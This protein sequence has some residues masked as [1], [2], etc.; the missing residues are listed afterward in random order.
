MG[1]AQSAA[2]KK[3]ASRNVF[4]Q[5]RLSFFSFEVGFALTF[6]LNFGA[7]SCEGYP[8][9]LPRDAKVRLSGGRCAPIRSFNDLY[10]FGDPFWEAFSNML[11][12]LRHPVSE[13]FFGGVQRRTCK[14]FGFVL[15][16][17]SEAFSV[18]FQE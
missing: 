15:G 13:C 12:C 17:F 16:A 2:L 7:F 3:L 4:G 9:S 11:L 5:P 8:Q 1:F 18:C 14:D 6:F 10:C